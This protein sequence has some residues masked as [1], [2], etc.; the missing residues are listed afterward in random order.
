M[1]ARSTLALVGFVVLFALYI[2]LFLSSINT[3]KDA[4]NLFVVNPKD[5]E[6][7]TVK[8]F[9]DREENL[10]YFV[11]IS[12][13]HLSALNDHNRSDDLITFCSTVLPVISPDI[14]ILTGDIT[15]SRTR[16][17]MGSRQ[18]KYEWDLYNKTKTSCMKSIP[19]LTWL[20]IRGNHGE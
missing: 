15:D 5:I 12:D 18:Y 13:T 2:G 14:L 16:D 10:F 3:N 1:I 4:G 17:P 20:D 19:D 7:D 9:D 6:A 8:V 11:Q